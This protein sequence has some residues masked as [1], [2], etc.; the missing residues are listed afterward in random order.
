MKLLSAK[1][2]GLFVDEKRSLEECTAAIAE[3]LLASSLFHERV[4]DL[5]NPAVSP[6]AKDDAGAPDSI[7][8]TSVLRL[9][10]RSF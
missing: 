7:C 3:E 5:R 4:A 10:L 9:L 2:R 1:S 6:C 8:V